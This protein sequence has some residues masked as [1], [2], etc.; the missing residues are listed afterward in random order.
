MQLTPKVAKELCILAHLGQFRRSGTIPYSDHPIAVAEMMSTD[1]EKILAYLH[2]VPEDTSARLMS[3][4]AN[5]MYYITFNGVNYHMDKEIFDQLQLITHK[6]NQP[7][8]EYLQ[9]IADDYAYYKSPTALKVKLA[10]IL[11]NMSSAPSEH[12]RQKY[13][14]GIQILLI[15]L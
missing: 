11:H 8:D 3:N 12:S 4:E 1:E 15:A 10:D 13:L 2:D 5:N 6:D 7:Y 9:A 14:R